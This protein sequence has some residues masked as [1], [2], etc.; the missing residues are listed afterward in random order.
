M[1]TETLQ[2][3]DRVMDKFKKPKPGDSCI[4][5]TM[6]SKPDADGSVTVY[7]DDGRHTTSNIHMLKPEEEEAKKE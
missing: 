2:I 3:G 7:W 1:T 6:M 4:T 5:G